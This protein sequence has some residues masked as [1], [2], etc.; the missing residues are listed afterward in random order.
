[1]VDVYLQMNTH[2][3][4]GITMPSYMHDANITLNRAIR[5]HNLRIIEKQIQKKRTTRRLVDR[6]NCQWKTIVKENG[7]TVPSCR[8]CSICLEPFLDTDLVSE[9]AHGQ[10]Y[11]QKE[12]TKWIQNPFL[13]QV[14]DPNTNV[15]LPTTTFCQKRHK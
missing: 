5:E 6:R 15:P 9:G 8:T 7:G 4:P 14:T 2:T 10:Y 12:F 11:H 3:M 1:M 13:R